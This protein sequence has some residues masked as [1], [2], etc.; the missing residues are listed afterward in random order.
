MPF[1]GWDEDK[2]RER[3]HQRANRLKEEAELAKP[4]PKQKAVNAARSAAQQPSWGS[5]QRRKQAQMRREQRKAI[6]GGM[7]RKDAQRAFPTDRQA[8]QQATQAHSSIP[9]LPG[10][11]MY[12]IALAALVMVILAVLR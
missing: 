9:A 10:C 1:K 4:G 12:V 5:A 2:P 11:M 7:S 8:V 6:K 3:W